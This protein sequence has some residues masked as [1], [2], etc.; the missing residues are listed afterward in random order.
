VLSYT[1]TATN[2][3][4]VTLSDV[5]IT[6]SHFTSETQSCATLA[7]SAT[8]VLSF[9]YTVTQADVDAGTI[10]NTGSA[11]SAE[12]DPVTA[13]ETLSLVQMPSLEVTK[14]VEASDS[15]LGDTIFY[16]IRVENTGN[17]TMNSIKLTDIFTD[18]QGNTLNLV[19]GPTF[20]FNSGSSEQGTLVPGELAEFTATYVIEQKAIDAGGVNNIAV[21]VAETQ[22]NE[23]VEDTSDDGDDSDNNS[24]DDPTQLVLDSEPS[25]TISKTVTANADEDGSGDISL[26]DTLTYTVTATNIGNVT[27][28][29][30]RIL[31]TQLQP[32]SALCA[33][34]LPSRDCQLIGTYS[35][36]QADVDSGNI[37]NIAKVTSLEISGETETQLHTPVP[38]LPAFSIEKVLDTE[39]EEDFVVGDILTYTVTVKNTGNQTLSDVVVSDGKITPAA[40]TC[41]SVP[42]DGVCQL[43]GIYTITQSD[44]DAG[45]VV[46]IA[47]AFSAELPKM[48][49]TTLGTPLVQNLRPTLS[50]AVS[51]LTDRDESGGISAG[52]L[53]TFT[54][55]LLND[56]ETELT[57]VHIFD[58]RV[59][60]DSET[61]SRLEPGA[62]CELVGSYK[63]T[64][65][66]VDAGNLVNTAT[67]SMAEHPEGRQVVLNTPLPQVSDFTLTKTF[68]EQ[69][70]EDEDG[71]TSPGDTLVYQV[72]AENIGNVTLFNV[73]VSDAIL[74]PSEKS[75][76]ALLPDDL[77]TLTGSYAV[78]IADIEAGAVNNIARAT[79]DNFA[80]VKEDEIS[81]PLEPNLAPTL[82][83]QLI[84]HE[85]IDGNGSV[86]V[87]DVLTYSVSLL[88]DGSVD[89]TNAVVSDSLI[90]PSSKTCAV[91]LPGKSCDLVG[92]Y[93]VTLED[94]QAGVIV[95]E[96]E[97]TTNEVPGPRQ[98]SVD[99]PV[100]VPLADLSLTKKV[101]I[102]DDKDG[103]TTLTPGDIVEFTVTLTNEIIDIPTG[104]ATGVIVRDK[105]Q[106][107]YGYLSDDSNGA[108][109]P[110][111]G[112]WYIGTLPLGETRALHIRALVLTTGSFTNIAEVTAS[113]SVDPDSLPGN[114]DGDQDEDDEAAAP[115]SPAVGL[116]VE[117]GTP[118]PRQN[119]N[120]TIPVSFIIENTGIVGLCELK[121]LDDLSQAFGAGNIV[122]VTPPVTAGTL[123]PNPDYDG[124]A[125]ANLLISDCEDST[126]STLPALSDAVVMIVVEVK[127]TAGVSIYQHSAQVEGKSSDL[128]NPMVQIPI[129]DISTAG[130]EPDPNKNNNAEENEPNIIELA[131]LPGVDVSI[132]ASVPI[133][134]EEGGYSVDLLLTVFNE[135]NLGLTNIDL[136]LPLA[137]FFPDGV[138]VAEEVTSDRG[139]IVLN[140]GY[141]GSDDARLF[142]FDDADGISSHLAVGEVV[143]VEVPVR[144]DPANETVFELFARVSANS[145]GGVVSDFS[146]DDV[147]AGI[148]GA[149]IISIEPI[150]VLGIAES[151]SPAVET[152]AASN[153]AN[154]CEL[155]PCATSLTIRAANVGNTSLRQVQIEQLL[156]GPDGLP[157]DT[158]VTITAI[159]VNGGLAGANL[160]L[161]GSPLTVGFDDPILLLDATDTLAVG[162][163]ATIDVDLEFLLPKGT[164][165]ERF[166]LAALGRSIDSNDVTI[167]D[168][169]N[170]GSRVDV[171]GNGPSDDKQPTP[172]LISNRPIIGV[173]AKAET[174]SAGNAIT[175]IDG[176]DPKQ[177]IESRTLTY[178][179]SL[180]IEVANLGNTPLQSVEVVN[181]LVGTFP[182][183]AADPDQP[184][185]VVEGS[186]TVAKVSSDADLDPSGLGR[187]GVG[188]LA[189]AGRF[190]QDISEAVN[191][192]FDGIT[193]VELVDPDQISLAVGESIVISYDLEIEIDY[194]DTLALEELQQQNFETQIVANGTDEGSGQTISDLSNDAAGVDLDALD[195]E[196]LRAELDADGDFDPNEAG[197]NTPTAVQFPTAIQGA[198][199]LDLD[200]DGI[201]TETDSPLENWTV[202]VFKAGSQSNSVTPA[203][204]ARG[205]NKSLLD[206]QGAPVSVVT[207]A[208]GYYSIASAP[209][210][211]Y[212]FEF[213]SPSGTVAGEIYGTGYSLQILNVQT[214][215]LNPRGMIYDSVTGNPIGGVTLTLADAAGNA[216]PESCL[217]VPAQQ[218]QIT[219]GESAGS[220][221]G[222]PPGAYEFSLNAGASPACPITASEYRILIDQG[223]LPLDYSLSSL[224]GPEPGTLENGEAGCSVA[225]VSVDADPETSLC[226]VSTEILPVVTD[227]LN[228]YYLSFNASQDSVDFVNNHIPLDPPLEGLVLLTKASLKDTIS[229]GELAPYTVRVEN[230]TQYAL[231]DLTVMDT[232]APGFAI[233]ENS[234]RL[235]RAGSDGILD[236]SDDAVTDVGVTGSRPV[237]FGSVFLA[238]RET[239]M[240]T[241]VMR[242]GSG[243]E[244]GVHQNTVVPI[245]AGQVVGNRAMA[246][247][248]VVA[249]PLFD[250]TT[251]IGKVFN[252][253]NAN[254]KQDEDESGIPGARIATVGGEWI[255][256]D[257]FGRFSLPGVDPGQNTRGRNAILKVDPASLPA[258]SQFTT[259]NP[260]VQRITG[261]LM[262]QFDFGIKLAEVIPAALTLF[263]ETRT[264]TK[265]VDAS[266][267]PVRFE[268]GEFVISEGYLAQLK[269]SLSRLSQVDNLRIVVEG[270]TDNEPLTAR[271][272]ARYVDN[273]GLASA[274]ARAVAEF[275][276][277]G[278]ALPMHQFVTQSYGAD[279]PIADNANEAGM[280]SNRRVEIRFAFDETLEELTQTVKGRKVVIEM[281]QSY[282]ERYALLQR[283]FP[284]LDQI[285]LALS[286]QALV[287]V[288][289]FIP[290]DEHYVSRRAVIVAYLHGLES[291]TSEHRQKVVIRRLE[292]V[293]HSTSSL[294]SWL[295]HITLLVL[296]ALVPS[297]LADVDVNC[298]NESLCSSDDLKIYVSEAP[299]SPMASMGIGGLTFADGGKIWYSKQP[300]RIDPRF[301]IRPSRY[302]IAGDKGLIKPAQF[303]MDS[304]FPDQ[305]SAWKLLIFDARD[306]LRSDPIAEVSGEQIP[307]GTPVIWDG[308]DSRTPLKQMPAV[309]YQLEF[310]DASGAV[311][312]VRGGTLDIRTAASEV[313]KP[314]VLDDLTWYEEIR[315]ENHLISQD[316]GLVGD[317][318][319]VH[320]TNLPSDA[321]LLLGDHR[322]P[323]GSSGKISISRQL[324][325]GKY[326]LPISVV[327]ASGSVLGRG[328]LPVTVEGEYFFM[329]G[330][331]DFTT[332]KHD[333]IGNLELLGDD[334][335]YDGDVY[336]DG[337]L[338]FYLKGQIKGRYLLTMQ[339]DTGED[340]IGEIFSDLDRNDPNRLFKR[341]DP[342]RLYPVYGDNSRV[343]RDVDTQGKFY[344]RM[345]WDRSQLLWGN[346]NTAFSGT[347]LSG[348]NRSLYG[349]KLDYRAS[350]KTGLNE[351]RHT[352][353]VF[354]SEPN[355][356]A[357][358]DE[359]RGT[360]GSLYYLS[361]SDLVLGSAKLVVE[362]RDRKSARIREQIE[363]VEGQDYEIDPYQGRVILTRPLRGSASLSV[364]S[365]IRE[366]P[367]D[368]DE[369][370]LIAD[371]EYV[372]QGLSG[373]EDLTAGIRGKTWISDHIGIGGTY[374]TEENQ[375]TEF[376]IR[377]IDL[378][379]KATQNS[380]LVV[381]ASETKAGQNLSLN[382]S[383]DG[384][385]DYRAISLPG[386]AIAGEAVSVTGQV[387]LEDLGVSQSGQVGF[388]YRDQQAGFNSVQYHNV[389][390]DDSLTYGVEAS[391]AVSDRLSLRSRIDHEERGA[392]ATYVDQGVQLSWQVSESMQLA[393]EYLAQRDDIGGVLD[394][395]STLG[396]RLTV[397]FS[398]RFSS[399]LNVQSVLDQ[400]ANSAMDDLVGLGFNLSVGEKTDITGEAFS[401]GDN[402]GARMGIGYRYRQNS[403]AYLN[404]VTERSDLS[405]DGLTLGQRTEITDRMRVYSEHRFD[406][407]SRQNVEGDSYGISYDFSN[408]WTVDGDILVGTTQRGS[409]QDE[410]TAYSA[411]SRFRTENMNLVNR[412]EYRIDENSG[413]ADRNQWVT[414]NRLNYRYSNNWVLLAKADYSKSVEDIDTVVDARFGEMDFGLAY[415]PV[416][417]NVLNLLAMASYVYDVDPTNQVGGLYVDEKGV[418][419]SIEGLYQLSARLKIGGKFAWKRSSIRLD[420]DSDDFV[421]A[422][423][424]LAIARLRYHLVWKLDALAEYRRLEVD[425]VGDQKQG[426]LL[427]VD[428]QL[429]TNFGIGIGYNF[430]DFNDRLTTLDYESKG[431]FLNLNGRL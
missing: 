230:L 189:Q 120:Y 306:V 301:A 295:S 37:A 337:R 48:L 65:T 193:E 410:R 56:S 30:M 294:K 98:A 59:S 172:L 133:L 376:E 184:L 18:A 402:Q 379:L 44:Q 195:F 320:A 175:L 395:S 179:A 382:R 141:D 288:E 396:S 261:G 421:K 373:S 282:F 335:H 238:A 24:V 328:S 305:I 227:G 145:S 298:L 177:P 409:V 225:G 338:A 278:L 316:L 118:V 265:I 144:F 43:T 22:L 352:F 370:V 342:D 74:T 340:D 262:N 123:V 245:L 105:L 125:N 426:V 45:E 138:T 174:D 315:G 240:M 1:L 7:P 66:D 398:D 167:T 170:N 196:A 221:L 216:L 350:Q 258:G 400:S 213:V 318:V 26:G 60:P 187:K 54:V 89:L 204:F 166:E 283:A 121:L 244:R 388:W 420:R 310:V 176:G 329:V 383:E 134:I 401:D 317:L 280:A 293:T 307:I 69:I 152:V 260:R 93:T 163:S 332:G 236:T 427:G 99:T 160:A 212:R 49:E 162:A 33:T 431:W 200:A 188:S 6:D 64:Q 103:S 92:T 333:L 119:G 2:T 339:L 237:S 326:E 346:Y 109:D 96:A 422:T 361:H 23:S 428:F 116:S 312:K 289:L 223:S 325:P 205:K 290:D 107:R 233:A 220:V 182:T 251:F 16:T 314:F 345:D 137:E 39:Q 250:L 185:K 303:W 147:A 136:E 14:I 27:L 140:T 291:L 5:V 287:Q 32:S 375:G 358:R 211:S 252:D 407:S 344:V 94:Q 106:G 209:A 392:D 146:L 372:S 336:V 408:A 242:V 393:A 277:R 171:N 418:V 424:T 63:V 311:H 28:T 363:L 130:P 132:S 110:D 299:Q 127:P 202:N 73:V 319:T 114:D 57:Q 87:G 387:H 304:N 368:G 259:E 3:G 275:L 169:S 224:R 423:T 397:Q 362:V 50:K 406:R 415:R 206:V 17:V 115:P 153:S 19:T 112:D 12:T 348:Y 302:L 71:K 271:A 101:G 226:E 68:T 150:G 257:E 263:K 40:V 218:N 91:L 77:C 268:S 178:G 256:T 272:A 82:T 413:P 243:V 159:S 201:C 180:K 384:G 222:L 253:V 190:K 353:K 10:V 331:A 357:A 378:T 165:I 313:D 279:R 79:A 354:A 62:S 359:L 154:R 386:L 86:T 85:D 139:S 194:S 255:T 208:A 232:Q 390:G 228:P 264:T 97:A 366:A 229:V 41:A 72:V 4:N 292:T 111:T 183:L 248:E 411:S 108:Y 297:A 203:G 321:I 128:G 75:C 365:I 168:L 164:L 78:T 330:L 416:D 254:G 309:A 327:D 42:L 90:E 191:V 241:Y 46:N 360:G 88:N 377:G 367:L 391:V 126:A 296:N 270:H 234:V 369:V 95:N 364:L 399:F 52:D 9:T 374:V 197:E 192:D 51:R 274:R 84:Q 34:V 308:S 247:V 300:G 31:D 198:A 173:L 81:V 143:R 186:L 389:G 135:G 113:T 36:T 414:T 403:S 239:V 129:V 215:M 323:T 149:A 430:T 285:A 343:T 381:E 267:E 356:K 217:A 21:A 219:G 269:S 385:L 249:D 351:D 8:C 417:N 161:I 58:D 429:G 80:D 394:D 151:A 76:A 104:A 102:S 235:R 131:L 276:S 53:L 286:D 148:D 405:R 324:P 349:L 142:D 281:T 47:S 404:Y 38:R 210:G 35:V 380:Y 334:E 214:L 11:D 425:E 157:E 155:D 355:T 207:D 25:Q 117:M 341:I 199:C 29:S 122:S 419:L 100:D 181:S 13:T 61:C 371:Y 124:E 347:E 231:S 70:D 158:I 156:S 273:Y 83:K 15:K 67:A 20:A 246:S 284:V 412:L 266:I 55:S 322:Y